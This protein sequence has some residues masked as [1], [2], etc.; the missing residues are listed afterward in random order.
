MEQ[1]VDSK[2]VAPLIDK[3]IKNS[4]NVPTLLFIDSVE[5]YVEKYG[6]ELLLEELN[7]YMNKFKYMEAQVIKHFEGVKGKLPDIEKA[8]EVIEYME[9]R[10]KSSKP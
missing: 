5:D 4:R 9:T 8:L 1:V 10:T 3:N 7:Q 2:M 6:A